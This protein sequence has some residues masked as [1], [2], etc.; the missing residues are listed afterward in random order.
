[1]HAPWYDETGQTHRSLIASKMASDKKA[2]A[3]PGSKSQSDNTPFLEL[4][5]QID[6]CLLEQQALISSRNKILIIAIISWLISLFMLFVYPELNQSARHQIESNPAAGKIM[7]PPSDATTRKHATE[8][9]QTVSNTKTD[10]ATYIKKIRRLLNGETSDHTDSIAV[11]PP[12]ISTVLSNKPRNSVSDIPGIHGI[13]KQE[14]I[15]LVY[16]WAL[17]WELQDTREYFSYYAKNFD[18]GWKAEDIDSW[19][20]MRRY[21]IKKPDWI[22]IKI[23]KLRVTKAAIASATVIFLQSYETPTYIDQTIKTLGLVLESGEW[24]I[25]RESGNIQNVHFKGKS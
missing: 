21:Y 4:H 19:K 5:K 1:M 10:A 13:K 17:A 12:R 6:Q 22:K 25:R 8:P 9:A 16:Q 18:P 14:I 23:D 24:K 20:K 15:T 11:P 2:A 7:P 3:A